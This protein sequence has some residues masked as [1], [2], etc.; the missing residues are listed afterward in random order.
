MAPLSEDFC[1]ASV[2]WSDESETPGV[3]FAG[4]GR[5]DRGEDLVWDI[6]W[7]SDQPDNDRGAGVDQ[8]TW[9]PRWC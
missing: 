3:E 6:V 7:W 5:V 1:C 4:L 8:N 9:C 2:M